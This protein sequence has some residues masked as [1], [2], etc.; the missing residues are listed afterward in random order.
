[1]NGTV[2]IGTPCLGVTT[3]ARTITPT[4]KDLNESEG[5]SDF[6]KK[7]DESQLGKTYQTS[8]NVSEPPFSQQ[9]P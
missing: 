2:R 3:V 1:M 6:I 7:N 5:E 9:F 8:T 4:G